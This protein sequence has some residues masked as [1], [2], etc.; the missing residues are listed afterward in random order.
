MAT[1]ALFVN[2]CNNK[3]YRPRA[4]LVQSQLLF[5]D[6]SSQ[7]L[8]LSPS[9]EGIKPLSVN[10]NIKTSLPKVFGLD[11][12]FTSTAIIKLADGFIKIKQEELAELI[13]IAPRNMSNIETGRTFPSP[14]NIE[15]IEKVLGVKIKDLFDFDHQQDDEDLFDDIV[16]R[17]KTLKRDKLQDFYKITRSLTD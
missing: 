1:F 6:L 12:P 5:V 11:L 9:P 15:K 4:L 3:N 13:N 2:I 17:I 8:P 10:T 14:E 7:F 16:S